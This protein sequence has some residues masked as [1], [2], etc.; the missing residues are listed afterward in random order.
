MN[1]GQ[2]SIVYHGSTPI[3]FLQ[4]LKSALE[5]EHTR[6]RKL[7]SRGGP[8]SWNLQGRLRDGPYP[9]VVLSNSAPIWLVKCSIPLLQMALFK[10]TSNTHGEIP[11]K[12]PLI[13]ASY[14]PTRWTPKTT[15]QL[16]SAPKAKGI[17]DVAFSGLSKDL[18]PWTLWNRLQYDAIW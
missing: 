1:N 11:S 4:R 17:I 16:R 6:W 5:L 15:H 13:T 8:A 10:G 18:P 7:L 2:T 14:L 3:P 12:P 9:R